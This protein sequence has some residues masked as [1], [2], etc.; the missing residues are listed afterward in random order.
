MSLHDLQ[1]ELAGL[2]FI[3]GVELEREVREGS[4]H[5]GLAAVVQVLG[6]KP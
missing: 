6:I 3:H 5:T 1:Q 2:E 4:R